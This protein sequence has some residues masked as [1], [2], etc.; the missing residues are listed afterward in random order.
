MK[1]TIGLTLVE[2]DELDK[3]VGN[4]TT[5]DP[6][7]AKRFIVDKFINAPL[8]LERQEN[9][10]PHVFIQDLYFRNCTFKMAVRVGASR[11]VGIID[12]EN[13][14]FEN[15]VYFYSIDNINLYNEQ[16]FNSDL[17][18][19]AGSNHEF[20]VSDISVAGTLKI[21]SGRHVKLT[22]ENINVG[23]AIEKQN[24]IID[25]PVDKMEVDHIHCVDLHIRSA[26]KTKV[27]SEFSN[28][29][30]DKLY[31]TGP[32][33]DT[34]VNVEKS[35]FKNVILEGITN[36]NNQ[37]ALSKC[38][39]EII[40]IKLS[41]ISKVDISD[42]EIEYLTL[43][44][45]NAEKNIVNIQN[46]KIT[47]W[48]RFQ[49]VY[50]KGEIFLRGIHVK[51]SSQLGIFSSDL[52]KTDFI[53][54]D[55]SKAVFEFENSKMTDVFLSETDFPLTARLKGV[56]NPAQAQLA[57]GQ[58]ATAYSKQGD[59]VKALEYQARE[60]EAHY[61]GLKFYSKDFFK[62]LNLGLNKW[63][64][65]F[66]RHWQRGV[67]FS[68]LFGIVFFYF[69]VISSDEYQVRFPIQMNSNLVMAF[70]K[71]MNPLRFLDTES[72]F[73]NGTNK[74]AL[75]LNGWSYVWDFVGRL[76][77]AYGFYQTI[78]AFRRFGRK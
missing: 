70:L 34:L 64:N 6:P 21:S 25:A 17:T 66:G 47:G 15:P 41:E 53:N 48:I 35:A 18:L 23:K 54:C 4:R 73:R 58:L 74:P 2:Q 36:D 71:F 40:S 27:G 42:C 72:L 61:A 11:N 24:I 69:L 37:V 75:T 45:T 78:Q 10:N 32:W 51:P 46:V 31:L 13:C 19:N 29:Q 56:A 9:P 49:K 68:I 52:G 7:K 8:L 43:N 14:I 33:S 50:N 5:L 22:V 62:I 26:V 59:T 12:F 55:F 39:V 77:V 57:F 67:I 16:S 44:E 76:V 1:M 28:I 60:I 30:C 3:L 65:N 63:S 38:S 20:K